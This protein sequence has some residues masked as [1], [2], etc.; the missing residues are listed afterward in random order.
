ML[1]LLQGLI[2]MRTSVAAQ[3]PAT[4]PTLEQLCEVF[5]CQL[6]LPMQIEQV[7]IESHE[8]QALPARENGFLLSMLLRNRS[9][10]A[11][12][13]PHIEL[14]LDDSSGQPVVRKVLV[15][16]DYVRHDELARGL[17]ASSEKPLRVSFTLSQL[18]ASG[19]RVYVF[20]P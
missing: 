18:K 5:G 6:H 1:A 13:W 16:E 9:T 7:T 3:W 12:A 15:P 11:Q 17:P 2:L 8:L 14:S 10:V 4:R 19:Y 20:Y